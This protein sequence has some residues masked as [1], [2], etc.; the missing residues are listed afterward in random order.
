VHGQQLSHIGVQPQEANLFPR[1]TVKETLQLFASFYPEPMSID[2]LINILELEPILNKKVKALSVGQRQRLLVAVALIGNPKLIILDEPTSGID[3]QI[4]HLIWDCLLE[5]K[6][7]NKTILLSTHYMDEAEKICDTVSI[8]HNGKIIVSDTPKNI[9]VNNRKR[10]TDNL[11]DVF[12]YLT[13]K[14]IRK[15]VD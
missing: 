6:E 15:E 7:K 3:P 14:E 4:R 8:L 10:M 1:Q 13:G 9:I 2:Y 5:M 12:I 11:E